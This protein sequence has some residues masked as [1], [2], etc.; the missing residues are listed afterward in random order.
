MKSRNQFIND[1]FAIF[2]DGNS[3]K[4]EYDIH[5]NDWIV[6]PTGSFIDFGIRIYN[7]SNVNSLYVYIPYQINCE[8]IQDLAPLFGNEKIARALTNTFAHITSSTTTPIIEITYYGITESI[9]FLS[10]INYSS[11]KCEEGTII[12]FSIKDAHSSIKCKNGYIRFRIPHK[13]LNKV[14]C[15]K[16]HNYKFTF[17]SP[18]IT[19]KYQ[20]TIKINEF[21]ALPSEVRQKISKNEQHIKKGHFYLAAI[22]KIDISD[23]ICEN[24]RP[25]ENNLFES[26]VPQ[27]FK[28]LNIFVYQ[29]IKRPQKYLSFNF[30]CSISKIQIISLLIYSLIIIMFS[31]IGNIIWEL[32]KLTLFFNWL[33]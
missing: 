5:I 20:H 30:K 14:F 21:R 6:Y 23:N 24:I 15:T 17:D 9:I 2:F 25:L 33:V 28:T 32:L 3:S 10:L 13:S 7:I 12:I 29:W 1:N 8:E 19:D 4:Y 22:E 27:T 18:I 11:H 16:K 26:Y 31:I